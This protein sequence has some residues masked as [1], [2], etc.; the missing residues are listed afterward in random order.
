MGKPTKTTKSTFGIIV[1]L[2]NNQKRSFRVTND[3]LILDLKNQI[4]AKEDILGAS[5]MIL[6]WT[7]V[8]MED[9]KKIKDYKVIPGGTITQR[10][11][12]LVTVEGIILSFEPDIISLDDSKEARA[13]MICGHAI[14]TESMTALIRS[15]ISEGRYQIICP[16]LKTD[17]TACEIEWSYPACRKI[18][19]L[20]R[21]EEKEFETKLSM[22]FVNRDPHMGECSKCHVAIWNEDL[23]MIRVQCVNCRKKKQAVDF[24]WRFLREWK[25][26]LSEDC[27]NPEC[28][29]IEYKI[30]S[31]KGVW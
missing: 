2:A 1:R 17:G 31:L 28:T 3:M 21:D 20:T 8:D 7:G 25:G 11:G 29:G 12:S 4:A 10:K 9:A 19:V 27:G 15:I 22:N 16:G 18:G 30:R 23:N 6:N 13:K 24:C 26:V 14:S 5:N